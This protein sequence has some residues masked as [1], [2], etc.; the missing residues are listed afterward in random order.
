MTHHIT[1]AALA[2]I[3]ALTITACE[4]KQTETKEPV[5]V[6]IQKVTLLTPTTETKPTS[7]VAKPTTQAAVEPVAVV[8][9]V[10]QT[11]AQPKNIV[12][13]GA[14]TEVSEDESVKLPRW[15]VFGETSISLV[16]GRTDETKTLQIEAKGRIAQLLPA[17]KI[18]PLV[19][20]TATASIWARSDSN[21]SVPVVKFSI[22]GSDDRFTF[23]L[24]MPKTHPLKAANR[25]DFIQLESTF[26]VPSTATMIRI[27]IENRSPNAG[28][29]SE[30][31]DLIMHLK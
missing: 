16:A 2:A 30:F 6:E 29:I 8:A 15:Q 31:S 22:E 7:E 10:V 20:K 25:S 9:E 13:N 18:W 26:D 24:G 21:A 19:G 5:Q 12:L 4:V 14:F 3:A 27:D 1:T 11:P 17:S 28:D 23:M